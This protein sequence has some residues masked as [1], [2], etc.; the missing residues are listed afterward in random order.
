MPSSDD[1][2]SQEIDEAPSI[3]HRVLPKRGAKISKKVYAVE[4][5]SDSDECHVEAELLKP[6]SRSEL[7]KRSTRQP[8]QREVEQ[9]TQSEEDEAIPSKQEKRETRMM[10]RSR[11]ESISSSNNNQ[12]PT[13]ATNPGK[14]KGRP[15]GQRRKTTTPSLADTQDKD[16]DE[17]TGVDQSPVLEYEVDFEMP[18][19]V[20]DGSPVDDEVKQGV[21]IGNEQPQEEEEEEVEEEMEEEEEDRSPSP[22]N[23]KA[24]ETAPPRKKRK[25]RGG[26][27]RGFDYDEHLLSPLSKV[28]NALRES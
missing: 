4:A 17:N 19:V 3:Q 9:E 13:I 11:K 22:Q 26:S 12:E 6:I 14:G 10:T 5:L 15:Q 18:M 7:P 28:N 21:E 27:K 1:E 8:K 20:L 16:N 25:L 2:D 23:Q 24:S